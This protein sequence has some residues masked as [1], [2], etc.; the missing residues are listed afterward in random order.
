MVADDLLI[1]LSHES[2]T[3]V[4]WLHA[5]RRLRAPHPSLR[6]AAVAGFTPTAPHYAAADAQRRQPRALTRL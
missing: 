6:A 5:V 1:E 3:F 2:E 4:S